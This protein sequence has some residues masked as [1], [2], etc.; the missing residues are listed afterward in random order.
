VRAYL[1]QT[2][3]FSG[4]SGSATLLVD[5]H[6][7]CKVLEGEVGSPDVSVAW[8]DPA[9]KVVFQ[10]QDRSLLPSGTE[11]PTV[12]AHT[13]KGRVALRRLRRYFGI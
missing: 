10:T 7:S 1:P 4:S 9:F 5:T 12:R 13:H 2:W 3:W 8:T 11:P 6:G